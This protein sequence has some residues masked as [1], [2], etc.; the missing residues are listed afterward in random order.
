MRTVE[1]LQYNLAN[2]IVRCEPKEDYLKFAI[3]FLANLVCSDR[4][5]MW[6]ILMRI[7][8]VYSTNGENFNTKDMLLIQDPN[9][10]AN[11]YLKTEIIEE[12]LL[13]CMEIA[14][15]IKNQEKDI[16]VRGGIAI[17]IINL[18]KSSHVDKY[19]IKDALQCLTVNLNPE[20]YM[21]K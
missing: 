21:D 11:N 14:T 1:D 17:I 19:I 5:E 2:I 4:Y 6:D 20:K 15:V 9:V 13:I 3:L 7:N 10:F 8:P 18:I 12:I 16:Q